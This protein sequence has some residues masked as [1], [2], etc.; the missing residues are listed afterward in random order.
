[1]SGSH[2]RAHVRESA[3]RRVTGES[4]SVNGNAWCTHIHTLMNTAHANTHPCA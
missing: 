2:R 3:S 1:M 4:G